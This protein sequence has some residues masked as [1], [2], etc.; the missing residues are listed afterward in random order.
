MLI[1]IFRRFL[2]SLKSKNKKITGTVRED[3]LI[4]MTAR[5][6]RL[7]LGVV[8]HKNYQR[9]CGSYDYAKALEFLSLCVHFRRFRLV[10]ERLLLLI[11]ML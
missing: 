3:L 5:L 1:D 11:R 9:S 10:K 8:G 6:K 2:L 7:P 4:F